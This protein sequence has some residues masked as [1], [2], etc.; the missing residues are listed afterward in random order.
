[1]SVSNA[2][3]ESVWNGSVRSWYSQDIPK[4]LDPVESGSYLTAYSWI[5]NDALRTRVYYQKQDEYIQE[6]ASD[7][8]K[9]WGKAVEPAQSFP[10]ARSGTGLAIV[11][12]PNTN[13][14][15]AKLFYLNIRGKLMSFDHKRNATSGGSW[16]NQDRWFSPSISGNRH[17]ISNF[18]QT[19]TVNHGSTSIPGGTHLTAILNTSGDMTLRIYFIRDGNLVEIRWNEK[20]GWQ[21]WYMHDAAA[22]GV[23]AVSNSN[24]VNIFFQT[25]TECLSAMGLNRLANK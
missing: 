1:M 16:Q 4:E 6:A 9:G 23:A 3:W 8:G 17:S 15:E 12:F 19:A 5:E 25:K 21:S 2:L 24:D 7:N 10:Q 20:G 18:P 13:D 11:P 22:L 14:R